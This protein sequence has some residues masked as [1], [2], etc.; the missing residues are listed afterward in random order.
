MATYTTQYLV[1]KNVQTVS[2]LY[3]LNV[4]YYLLL[5]SSIKSTVEVLCKAVWLNS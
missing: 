5:H 1:K 2:S 3:T 4:L